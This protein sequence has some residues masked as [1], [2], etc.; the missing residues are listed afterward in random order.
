MGVTTIPGLALRAHQH[1]AITA[2]RLPVPPRRIYA[3]NPR[4]SGCG[5][6]KAACV[7][8]PAGQ[9]YTGSYHRAPRRA[10]D[11]IAIP[12]TRVMILSYTGADVSGW[13]NATFAGTA[14]DARHLRA[15]QP[16]L[17]TRMFVRAVG[18]RCESDPP[19]TSTQPGRAAVVTPG[20]KP[21]SGWSALGSLA[22]ARATS[23]SPG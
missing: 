18:S 8:A 6:R 17:S 20:D 14:P 5:A 1:P 9:M 10:A 4:A 3:A 11:A 19:V 21:M 15:R 16:A 22:Q 13:A 23:R 2:T 12:Q 7:E